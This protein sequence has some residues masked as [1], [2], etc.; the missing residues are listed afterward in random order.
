MKYLLLALALFASNAQAE[1]P[2]VRD[3]VK[4]YGGMIP[5]E[6]RTEENCP[7]LR[8]H[9]DTDKEFL[10]MEDKYRA[11]K[12]WG[13]IGLIDLI[14]SSKALYPEYFNDGRII[15][16]AG[17]GGGSGTVRSTQV[18]TPQAGYQIIQ[19]GSS[20]TVIQTSKSK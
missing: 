14:K 6:E 11:K 4:W 8:S 2:W 19:S 16:G 10:A 12:D 20:I 1:A 9:W 3:C 5:V 7:N 13:M 18:I 15:A 17:T